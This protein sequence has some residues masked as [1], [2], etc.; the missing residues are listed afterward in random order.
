MTLREKFINKAGF[1]PT[2][3]HKMKLPPPPPPPK[4]EVY[5]FSANDRDDNVLFGNNNTVKAGTLE[6]L[7][8]RLTSEKYP[9]LNL[10]IIIYDFCQDS[11]YYQQ[12]I[13]PSDKLF[14]SHIERSQ[15][16]ISF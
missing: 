15:H 4:E 13:L 8:E 12:K 7:V 10:L 5:T 3:L 9:G 2:G 6:K 16:P 1:N 14:S 11:K